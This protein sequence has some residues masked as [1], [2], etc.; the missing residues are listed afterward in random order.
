MEII[1]SFHYV[2]DFL[3]NLRVSTTK[4]ITSSPPKIWN[5]QFEFARCNTFS[6]TCGKSVHLSFSTLSKSTV[7]ADS[8]HNL[9]NL[10]FSTTMI[11]VVRKCVLS[12]AS[13]NLWTVSKHCCTRPNTFQLFSR[14]V[15][16]VAKIPF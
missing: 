5:I 10:T 3:Q 6:N 9:S 8:L 2:E 12:L 13:D 15:V 16:D 14:N 4:S 7:S 1:S 11:F